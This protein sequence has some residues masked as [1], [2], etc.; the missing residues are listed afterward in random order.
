MTLHAHTFRARQTTVD[1][2][3]R[4][5]PR[6]DARWVRPT[7][8]PPPLDIQPVRPEMSHLGATQRTEPW[9]PPLKASFPSK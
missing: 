8:R 2:G 5:I 9:A 1:T 7:F 6:E 3:A 4:A